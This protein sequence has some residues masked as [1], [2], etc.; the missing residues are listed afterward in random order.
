M[1]WI[2]FKY[3]Q[4]KFCSNMVVFLNSNVVI[5]SFGR[6]LQIMKNLHLIFQGMIFAILM[7][8]YSL[9][10]FLP[11]ALKKSIM[12]FFWDYEV[13]QI[14]NS[15]RLQNINIFFANASSETWLKNILKSSESGA[16][17]LTD[18]LKMWWVNQSKYKFLRRIGTFPSFICRTVRLFLSG[19]VFH[20]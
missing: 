3:Y 12:K 6:F 13:L 16:V 17:V 19:V 10:I 8:Y 1:L 15:I 11:S 14:S 20:S 9:Y 5:Y 2:F 18:H 7:K 4:H